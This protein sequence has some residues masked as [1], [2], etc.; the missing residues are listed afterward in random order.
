MLTP[1]TSVCITSILRLFTIHELGD[2]DPTYTNVSSAIWTSVECSMAVIC[3]CLPT[4]KPLFRCLSGS[5]K[6]KRDSI[7]SLTP[8]S[9]TEGGTVVA[10]RKNSDFNR[11]LSEFSVT[12]PKQPQLEQFRSAANEKR[13]E[14]LDISQFQDMV[15]SPTAQGGGGGGRKESWPISQY[16][17]SVYSRSGGDR[18]S[19]IT[20]VI[21]MMPGKSQWNHY[22]LPGVEEL[23]LPVS[24]YESEPRLY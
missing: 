14:N 9:M 16:Q 17:E 1:E 23:K 5:R 15:Y 10:Q 6:Y 3:A 2:S 7:T 8:L 12:S 18:V 24:P 13:M 11:K 20:E 22:S 4:Y 19:S 21:P